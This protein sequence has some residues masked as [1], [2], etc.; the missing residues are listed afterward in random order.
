MGNTEASCQLSCP[1]FKMR[2]LLEPRVVYWIKMVLIKTSM[3]HGSSNMEDWTRQ[4][5]QSFRALESV[6]KRQIPWS[7]GEEETEGSPE[8]SGQQG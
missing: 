4:L 5:S 7:A 2:L 3:S 6:L 8:F 1:G